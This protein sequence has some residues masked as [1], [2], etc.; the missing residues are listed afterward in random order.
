MNVA[1]YKFKKIKEIHPEQMRDLVRKWQRSQE[2]DICNKSVWFNLKGHL[3]KVH[4]IVEKN[5]QGKIQTQTIA[6]GFLT[7]IGL[8]LLGVGLFFLFIFI[9]FTLIF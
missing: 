2:C 9:L 4:G 1:N 8:I 5:E 6:A 7:L 3:V